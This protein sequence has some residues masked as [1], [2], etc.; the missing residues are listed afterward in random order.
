MRGIKRWEIGLVTA[1][2]LM[3]S[4]GFLYGSGTYRFD[5]P[6]GLSIGDILYANRTDRM[7]NLNVG[8]ANTKLVGGAT[9]PS[10]Q[11]DSK[12]GAEIITKT[13]STGI[14]LSTTQARA[15]LIRVRGTTGASTIL[16]PP[17][18]AGYVFMIHNSTT[19]SNLVAGGITIANNKTAIIGNFGGTSTYNRLVA[20]TTP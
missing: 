15:M 18:T 3:L 4:V 5:V 17:A 2:V 20:D 1:I 8:A 12:F 16:T 10:Y 14:T 7:T 11:D 19:G 6:K 13:D 9:I